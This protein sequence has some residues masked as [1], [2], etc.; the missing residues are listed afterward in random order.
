MDQ[1]DRQHIQMEIVQFVKGFI[2]TIFFARKLHVSPVLFSISHK[3]WTI[4]ME[5]A[6]S[7]RKFSGCHKNYTHLL[8]MVFMLSP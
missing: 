4:Q 2:C 3:Q 8:I 5:L 1:G 6:G 7:K